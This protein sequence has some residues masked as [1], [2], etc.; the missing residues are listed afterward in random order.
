LHCWTADADFRRAKRI[1]GNTSNL[2]DHIF[3]RFADKASCR[4]DMRAKA[5]M[6]FSYDSLSGWRADT[7]HSHC[8]PPRNPVA[9]SFLTRPVTWYVPWFEATALILMS[10]AGWSGN[11][12]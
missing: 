8:S 6:E 10:G 9:T 5:V 4:F 7:R 1:E 12:L 11:L 3:R 2:R